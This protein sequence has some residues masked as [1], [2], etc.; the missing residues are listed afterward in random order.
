MDFYAN[1]MVSKSAAKYVKKHCLEYTKHK[2]EVGSFVFISWLTIISVHLSL[3]SLNFFGSKKGFL[4]AEKLFNQ[5]I[6]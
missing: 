5:R 3:R 2:L 1:L 6:R 4:S